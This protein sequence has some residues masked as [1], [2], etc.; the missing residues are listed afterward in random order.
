LS[1]PLLKS[2]ISSFKSAAYTALH[3]LREF[4]SSTAKV[5]AIATALQ[6]KAGNYKGDVDVDRD[7]DDG[8][9]TD[10]NNDNYTYVLPSLDDDGL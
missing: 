7:H 9:A 6:R 5:P 3:L 1:S 8:A 10:G 2:R 4:Q